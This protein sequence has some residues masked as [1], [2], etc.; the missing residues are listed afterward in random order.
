LRG[1][2]KL[3][4]AR[5]GGKKKRIWEMGLR[6]QT[7]GRDNR[8]DDWYKDHLQDLEMRKGEKTDKNTEGGMTA[9]FKRGLRST[10]KILGKSPRLDST[11]AKKGPSGSHG[12]TE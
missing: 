6:R 5:R 2:P 7:L 10:W 11:G 12:E 8:R 9:H 4:E 3:P 1:D